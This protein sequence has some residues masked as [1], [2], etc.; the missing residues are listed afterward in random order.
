MRC[1]LRVPVAALLP[2]AGDGAAGHEL[3]LSDSAPSC[4]SLRRLNVVFRAG[5]VCV[6]TG[7]EG[8]TAAEEEAFYDLFP[9]TDRSAE[10]SFPPTSPLALPS[11]PMVHVMVTDNIS[12]DGHPAAPGL[13]DQQARTDG[14]VKNG[15]AKG[16]T[17]SS[18]V[19]TD[20]KLKNAIQFHHDGNFWRSLPPA[21]T[22]LSCHQRTNCSLVS[23]QTSADGPPLEFDGGDTLFA[24]T[25]VS[26]LKDRLSPTRMGDVM[27]A[28]VVYQP[29]QVFG[30]TW[31]LEGHAIHMMDNGIRPIFPPSWD[32]DAPD[33]AELSDGRGLAP[34]HAAETLASHS[35]GG[36]KDACLE[37][38]PS[39][40]EHFTKTGSGSGQTCRKS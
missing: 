38:F 14:Y 34:S 10:M 39:I 36:A 5:G 7:Q 18:A 19:F 29:R 33:L 4:S 37:P 40:H 12:L 22:L 9:G 16:A 11:A 2:V 31:S 30:K 6:F 35:E 8:I 32:Q 24:S 3:S 15:D 20:G 17:G 13:S 1:T 21:W 23:Q 28:K 26:L 27:G 25:D